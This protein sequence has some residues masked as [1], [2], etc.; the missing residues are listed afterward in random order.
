[1]F[2]HRC[3]L[4]LTLCPREQ[5]LPQKFENNGASSSAILADCLVAR[6]RP[7]DGTMSAN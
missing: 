1:M 7:P 6:T 2:E 5:N 4:A 3:T